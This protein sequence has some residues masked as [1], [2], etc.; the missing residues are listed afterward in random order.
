MRSIDPAGEVLTLP[1]AANGFLCRLCTGDLNVGG[2]KGSW[3]K[4][5]TLDFTV[6]PILLHEVPS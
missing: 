3:K 4:H 2:L 1:G 5:R 6:L